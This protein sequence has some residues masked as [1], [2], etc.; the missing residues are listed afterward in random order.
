MVGAFL[1]VTLLLGGA[2]WWAWKQYISSPPYVDEERFP[3]RGFDLSAHNGYANLNAAKEDG[4]E[5]V[6]LKAS[7][8][9]TH[10]DENFV[11]NYQKARHAGMRIGAYHYFRFDRDGVEQAVNFLRSVG[12]RKLELGLA[13]DVEEFGN[14][15]D[16]PVDSIRTR[17]NMMVEYLNMKGHRITFYSN[18]E[19]WMK[20]LSDDFSGMPMWI[21]SFSEKNA[22]NSDWTFWQFDHHGKVAGIRGEVDLNAFRGSRQEWEE[23][24]PLMP[25]AY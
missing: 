16:V 13:I 11:L 4:Y 22:L 14:A 7:E 21:C 25:S 1:I 10:R 6:F 20:Y 9:V 5:F 8:G 12:N 23:M 19:G 17:L 3:I 15:K 24:F 2:I 18:R